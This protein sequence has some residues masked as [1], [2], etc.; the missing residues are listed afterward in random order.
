MIKHLKGFFTLEIILSVAIMLIITSGLVVAV[1]SSQDSSRLSKEELIANQYADY[2][3]ESV[4]SIR[5][6]GYQNLVNTTGT[7]LTFSSSGIVFVGTSNIFDKYNLSVKIEDAFRDTDG[8]LADS[9]DLDPDIKKVTSTVTW[10]FSSVRNNSVIQSTYMSRWPET[11]YKGI[12]AYGDGGT[13]SDTIKYKVFDPSSSTWGPVLNAADIDTGSSNKVLKTLKLYSD[14][15]SKEKI[16][17]S[18]HYDGTTKHIYAQVYNGDSWGNVQ[19]LSSYLLNNAITADNYD[20]T[21]LNNGDFIVMYIDNTSIPKYRVWSGTTWSSE[22]SITD[23]GSNQVPTV[24]ILKTRPGTDELMAAFVTDQG[25]TI[26][27]YYSGSAWSSPTTHYTSVSNTLMQSV[28]FEWDP[29]NPTIGGLIYSGASNKKKLTAKIFTANGS[30]GGS[31]SSADNSP[32][33]PPAIGGVTVAKLLNTNYY[34]GCNKDDDVNPE[35]ACYRFSQTPVWDNPANFQL[36]TVIPAGIQKSYDL[37]LERNSAQSAIVVYSDNTAVPKLKKYTISSNTFDA[38]ATN[39]SMGSFSPGTL[40]LV[41]VVP[42]AG[43]DMMILL[44]DT[45]NDLYTVAWDGTNNTTYTTPAILSASRHGTNGSSS[46][47]TWFDFIL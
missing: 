30:G 25:D 26:T 42:L 5:N 45:N 18:K 19:R 35:L 31:W 39:I 33:S 21:Y 44:A 10:D 34:L 13:T 24:I 27:E 36:T 40:K 12:L 9:G 2:G 28:D 23:L 32:A 20:G 47:E 7:G 6:Q 17:I 4:R 22:Q 37:S 16:M 38:S 46:T 15:D 14:Y 43:D 8:N 1:I 3:I 11:F 41:R 29:N